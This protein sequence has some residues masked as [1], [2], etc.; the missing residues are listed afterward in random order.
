MYVV[1]TD[2][3]TIISARTYEHFISRKLSKFVLTGQNWVQTTCKTWWAFTK[4]RKARLKHNCELFVKT[5][6]CLISP[7]MP[8]KS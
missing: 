3:I 2:E 5:L 4:S 6:H 8:F 1:L 7:K